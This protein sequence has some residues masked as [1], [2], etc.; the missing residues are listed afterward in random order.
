MNF[1]KKKKTSKPLLQ[2]LILKNWKDQK[3]KKKKK[4]EAQ[5]SSYLTIDSGSGTVR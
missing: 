2:F 1:T 4:K 3:R 5:Y